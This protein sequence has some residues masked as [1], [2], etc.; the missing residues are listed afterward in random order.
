MENSSAMALLLY[1]EAIQ[2]SISFSLNVEPDTAGC[3]DESV[4]DFAPTML[5]KAL[6]ME[7]G[8]AFLTAS[9]SACCYNSFNFLKTFT[10]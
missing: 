7:P 1:P 5:R 8:P 10:Q 6:G 2:A 9:L 3:V 4:K